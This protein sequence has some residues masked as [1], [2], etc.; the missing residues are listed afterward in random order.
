MIQQNIKE[1][2]KLESGLPWFNPGT[3]IGFESPGASFLAVN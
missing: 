3:D 2:K 1:K